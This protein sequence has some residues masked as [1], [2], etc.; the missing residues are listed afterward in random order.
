[1]ARGSLEVLK[2]KIDLA[3]VIEMLNQA[4]AE[5]WLAFYQYWIGAQVIKGM[6]RSQVQTEFVEHAMEE[7]AHADRLAARIVE[8]GGT[9]VLSPKE[10][11][12]IAGCAYD[13]PVND[14]VVVVLGQNVIAE[15]CAIHRYK[16]II[17]FTEGKDFTTCDLAKDIM[18]E[19]EEHEQE[20]QDFIDDCEGM[21]EYITKY[22]KK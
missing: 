9:P 6:Q 18:R 21:A 17:D 4:L 1:M 20:L 5:E 16:K 12:E 3:K 2:N 14:D 19:E 13:A 22:S 11:L 10:W 8:L 7:Y 15:R